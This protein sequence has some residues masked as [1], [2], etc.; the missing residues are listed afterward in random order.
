MQANMNSL[1]PYVNLNMST[2]LMQAGRTAMLY[3]CLS[4]NCLH[5][6]LGTISHSS[7][8]C[9]SKHL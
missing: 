6:P 3:V 5:L 1:D 7:E 4:N 2:D 8:P 9:C